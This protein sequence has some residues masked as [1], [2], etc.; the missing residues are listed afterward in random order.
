MLTNVGACLLMFL[1]AA[2]AATVAGTWDIALETPQGTVT[3]SMTLQQ[4][5]EKITGAYH[6][7]RFGEAPLEGTLRGSDIR[8]A[9]TFKFEDQPFTSS[10]SGTV[11]GDRMKGTVRFGDRG[12]GEW[13]AKKRP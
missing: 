3:P 7:T 11:A 4:E 6:S 10:F 1:L 13:T 12:S 9:V 2:Q 8:F 5:G